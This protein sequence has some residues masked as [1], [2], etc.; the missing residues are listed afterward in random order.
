[1]TKASDA[2]EQQIHR[3]HELVDGADAEVTW[4]DR[5]PDPDNP[6]QSRQIDI[7]IKRGDALTLVECRIHGELQDVKWIEELI[8]RRTSLQ[9]A[10]VIAVS[11]SGFTEG[12]ILKAKAHG[13]F[14][15]DLEQ[16]TPAEIEQWGCTVAMTLYYYQYSDLEL[17]LFFQPESIGKLD[18]TVLA[19]EVKT[20][21]G[22]QSLFNAAGDELE[23]LKLLTMEPSQRRQVSFKLRLQ[24]ED[25]Y[26]CCE[27]VLEV[28]FSG[29]AELVE[30]LLDMPA[31]VAYR[32]PADEQADRRVVMQR[33]SLGETGAI[34]HNADR[35]ATVLDLS[36]AALPPNCQFCYL[37]TTATK[38]MDMDSFEILGS[39]GMYASG[40][41]MTVTINSWASEE[42][43]AS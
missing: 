43:A 42:P 33:T 14:V 1:M 36:A 16:L 30:Q 10:A 15:R 24:L 32:D 7:T 13:I 18:M 35:M 39:V 4:N 25:F 8:G 38:E 2:F 6:K 26:L 5:I 22:R 40:G 9:A 28:K 31:V 34:V 23:K 3:L 20:Y 11:A 12:A 19:H 37:R 21:R 27:P 41:P 29:V 17:A